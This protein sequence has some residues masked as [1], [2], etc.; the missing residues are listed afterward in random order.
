MDILITGVSSQSPLGS[1]EEEVVQNLRDELL[2][3]KPYVDIHGIIKSKVHAPSDLVYTKLPRSMNSPLAELSL[4]VVLGALEDAGLDAGIFSSRRTGYSAAIGIPDVE[5]VRA[6]VDVTKRASAFDIIKTVQ[7]S[8]TGALATH[9]KMKGPVYTVQHACASG[10]RSISQGMDLI[11]LGK[12]DIVIC[13]TAED[14]NNE[15]MKG[16]DAMRALY[17]GDDLISPSKPFAVDR[18]G[19]V[20]GEGAGSIILETQEHFDGRNGKKIYG[21]LVS[22]ADY[23]DGS[24]ITNPSG[25]GATASLQE[26]Y[27]HMN[28]RNIPVDFVSAHA[29]ATMNGDKAEAEA[30]HNVMGDR[31]PVVAL[32]RLYG[33]MVTASAMVEFVH[34]LYMLKE[35]FVISN[36]PYEIDPDCK[37]IYLPSE[38]LEIAKPGGFIKNAFGFGGLNSV[39]GVAKYNGASVK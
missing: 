29:T 5:R 7:T 12:A 15:I 31:I 4:T 22:Y 17:R 24:D 19:F 9:L 33:H 1:T 16:F 26:V 10:L 32:K 2:T 39:V 14:I 20:Y 27:N 11:R 36:G 28:I 13:S 25:E 18:G 30:I 35:G 34:C 37:P 23:S 38:Q 21:K 8:V 3:F 6:L